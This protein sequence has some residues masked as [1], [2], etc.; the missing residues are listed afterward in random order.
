MILHAQE[1]K[2]CDNGIQNVL[3][4]LNKCLDKIGDYVEK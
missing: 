4:R 1:A 2:F 3:P